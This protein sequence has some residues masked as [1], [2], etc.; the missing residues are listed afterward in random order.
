M[1]R[2]RQP[3]DYLGVNYYGR[4]VVR[5][6]EHGRP[7][8]VPVVPENELT[9]MGWEVFPQGLTPLLERLVSDY[10]PTRLYITENGV[11]YSD[12]PDR[13]GR[14]RDVRR[15]EFLRDHIAAAHEAIGRGVPLRGYF[16]WS[17]LDNFEWAHGYKMRFGLYWVDYDTLERSAKD[18]AGWY[19]DVIAQNAV[20]LSTSRSAEGDAFDSTK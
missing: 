10:D 19:R 6:T 20:E 18:S 4:V 5:A 7:E 14:I 3:L 13:E 9:D 17:L 15:I 1:D 12:G 16:A 2:I 11:A 8:A